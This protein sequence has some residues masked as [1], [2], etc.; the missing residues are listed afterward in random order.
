MV[1]C[2]FLY[3]FKINQVMDAA[4]KL[5]VLLLLTINVKYSAMALH[6]TMVMLSLV[7]YLIL[8]VSCVF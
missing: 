1:V 2:N 8:T 5:M 3:F 4:V 7:C 6:D